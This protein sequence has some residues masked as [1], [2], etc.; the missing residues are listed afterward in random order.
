MNQKY[1]DEKSRHAFIKALRL[2]GLLN[3]EDTNSATITTK[4]YKYHNV[5][6]TLIVEGYFYP[7]RH[8]GLCLMALVFVESSNAKARVSRFRTECFEFKDWELS[9]N[10]IPDA[11]VWL[12]GECI[13]TGLNLIRSTCETAKEMLASVH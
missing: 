4:P 3:D 11:F 9:P 13:C 6:G 2:A 5:A 10:P 12:L 8:H 7:Y 1:Q